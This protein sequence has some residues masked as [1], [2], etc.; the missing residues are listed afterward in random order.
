M[1]RVVAQEKLPTLPLHNH[2]SPL[3]T[4]L[5]SLPHHLKVIGLEAERASKS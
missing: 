1:V 5:C 3:H 2:H 4:P